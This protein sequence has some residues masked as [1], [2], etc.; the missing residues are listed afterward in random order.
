MTGR[1]L[2]ARISGG[3]SLANLPGAEPSNQHQLPRSSTRGS[4]RSI[5]EEQLVRGEAWP[6]FQADDILDTA[7]ILDVGTVKLTS[8]VAKPQHM[9]RVAHQRPARSR[10]T[11]Q[12]FLIWR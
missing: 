10:P 2:V 8:A 11:G 12:R 7:Q 1:P 4:S 3:S 5:S 6:A 9:A